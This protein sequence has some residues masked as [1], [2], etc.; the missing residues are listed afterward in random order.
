MQIS[1]FTLTEDFTFESEIVVWDSNNAFVSFEL[2]DEVDEGQEKNF[3]SKHI[4]YINQ[5]IKW[6][7]NNRQIIEQ[8]LL[9]N[10]MLSLAEEYISD[11]GE[12]I[13]TEEQKSFIVDGQKVY[14]PISSD[15]FF[16]AVNLSEIAFE[17]YEKTYEAVLYLTFTPDYFTGHCIT[18]RINED[19]QIQCY[20]EG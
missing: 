16:R 10:G 19:N 5:R 15:E 11:L 14:L 3:L 6:I 1:D 17:F 12:K 20:L 2:P 4:D 7:K 18:T 8:A 13:E 9:D